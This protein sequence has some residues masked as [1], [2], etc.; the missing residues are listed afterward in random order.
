M[1]HSALR[2]YPLSVAGQFPRS[3]VLILTVRQQRTAEIV[4]ANGRLPEKLRK[5]Y[6]DEDFIWHEDEYLII[7]IT[8]NNLPILKQN[9]H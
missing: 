1:N 7:F 5:T 3:D 8:K 4:D 2:T 6:R 9:K